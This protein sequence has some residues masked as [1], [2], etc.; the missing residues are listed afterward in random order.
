MVKRTRNTTKYLLYV[1]VVYLC[2]S[3]CDAL[4]DSLSA[5]VV[6]QQMVRSELS[7]E[8][9]DANGSRCFTLASLNQAKIHFL[10]LTA[11]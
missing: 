10:H 1:Y 9:G 4:S 2:D 5:D 8:K 7:H 6:P 3:S 11:R